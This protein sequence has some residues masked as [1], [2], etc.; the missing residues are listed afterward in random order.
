MSRQID[1]T[2]GDITKT[3][4]KLALPI[5]G[6]S[7][8]NMLYNLTDM[9]WLGRLSTNAVAGAGAVGFFIWFGMGLAMISQVGTAVGVSQSYGRKDFT[10]LRAYVSNAIKLDVFIAIIYSFILF[11]YKTQLIGFFKLE[12]IE[13]VNMAYDYMKIISVGIIF[14][15]LNPVLSASFN[16]TGNSLIPFIINSIGLVV[17]IILDPVLIFGLGGFPKMGIT[18]AAL[19]TVIA[20]MV[21][22]VTFIFAFIRNRDLLGNL[23]LLSLPDFKY[24]KKILKLGLPAFFQ[25]AIHSTINMTIARI[26]SNWGSTPIAVQS[27]GSQIES[28]SW[29]T[30]EGFSTAIAAFV[31]QNY[32]A[33]NYDRVKEGYF[34]GLKIVSTI[35]LFS[36]LLFIFGGELIFSK[37]TPGDSLAISQGGDYLRILGYCQVFMCMEIASL[38]VFNGIGRTLPPSI[39]GGVLNAL[40]I[41]GALVLSATALGLSGV[42]WSISISSILKGIIST[43]LCV[44]ILRNALKE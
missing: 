3:L 16:A 43:S 17:N 14:H 10:E 27:I 20:Q 24:I 7:L 6:T 9:M 33:R 28:I 19:A 44:Y 40:R 12:E 4:T 26:L 21:V 25:T 15:F 18:G 32:G 5:M 30:A 22:T 31:G 41:P 42:W 13:A 11:N 1:L 37:F 8:I 23:K 38:G 36:A 2:Q 35:G 39:I 29:M 34:K